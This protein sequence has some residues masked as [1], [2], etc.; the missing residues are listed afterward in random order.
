MVNLYLGRASR[1]RAESPRV[2][3]RKGAPSS[4]NTGTFGTQADLKRPE[5]SAPI[6]R[7]QP[8]QAASAGHDV[9]HE[10]LSPSFHIRQPSP[11]MNNPL[12]DLTPNLLACARILSGRNLLTYTYQSSHSGG[13]HLPLR[14]RYGAKRRTLY[15][16]MGRRPIP[17]HTSHLSYVGV[18]V[19][20]LTVI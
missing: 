19:P 17:S 5:T 15:L 13:A 4:V 16:G 3:G 14:L 6:V 2:V 8:A 1:R 18:P 9:T 11:Q 12:T 7:Y 20:Y 10:R